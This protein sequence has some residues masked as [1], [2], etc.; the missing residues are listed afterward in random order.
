MKAM[1]VDTFKLGSG[2]SSW[3]PRNANI[4][5]PLA[6]T[7]GIFTHDYVSAAKGFGNEVEVSVGWR[8]QK[9]P[10]LI[11]M[12][13]KNSKWTWDNGLPTLITTLIQMN[14]NGYLYVLPDT[15]GGNGYPKPPSKELYIRW[16]QVAVFMPAIQLSYPPWDFDNEVIR[17]FIFYRVVEIKVII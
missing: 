17:I 11:K 3:L 16:L 13:E 8:T 4:S 1:G 12:A 14:L 7:P 15:V 2:E 10:F 6:M 9:L 5:G